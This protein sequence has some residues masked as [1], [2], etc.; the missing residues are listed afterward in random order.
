MSHQAQM[1]GEYRGNQRAGF[2]QKKMHD[3]AWRFVGVGTLKSSWLG[4]YFH[5]PSS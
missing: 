4:L 1:K 2:L 5:T 3:S